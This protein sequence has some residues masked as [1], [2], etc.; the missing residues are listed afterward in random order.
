MPLVLVPISFVDVAVVVLHRAAPVFLAILPIP[1][2]PMPQR[3]R[4]IPVPGG[5]TM[6]SAN[7]QSTP[8]YRCRA[9]KKN[10]KKNVCV[11]SG[12]EMPS[13]QVPHNIQCNTIQCNT[14]NATLS[15]ATLSN[16]TLSNATLSPRT[17]PTDRF[18]I[19]RC[20]RCRSP[21]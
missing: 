14:S 12:L 1:N 2:V 17:R 7:V 13:V 5:R 8:E 9:T 10:T 18:E 16:A 3:V 19:H 11:E 20:T 21:T 6:S 4:Q 15:N